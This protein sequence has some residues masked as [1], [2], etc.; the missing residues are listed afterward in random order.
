VWPDERLCEHAVVLG[1]TGSGKT[2][3]LL[4]LALAHMRSGRGLFFLDFH[5][6][7]AVELTAL[8]SLCPDAEGRFILFDPTNVQRSPG[9]N[10]LAVISREPGELFRRTSELAKILRARWGAD[11]LGVR[12]EETLRNSLYVLAEQG[13]TLV[14]LPLLL[15]S[16]AVR[17]RLLSNTGNA[18]V[19]SFWIDR[20]G[21]LSDSMRRAYTEPTIN[22]I[23]EFIGD[24]AIRHILGQTE[25]TV[26][27]ADAMQQGKWV[28]VNLAKGVLGE[29]SYLLGNL[30]MAHLQAEVMAR[31]KIPKAERNV[32]AL[33][34]DEVQN[35]AEND[36]ATFLSETRKFAISVCTASQYLLQIPPYLRGAL[37]IAG[38]QMFFRLSAADAATLAPELS[39]TQRTRY[40][41]E[42]TA[43]SRGEAVVR[44]GAEPPARIRVPPLPKLTEGDRRRARELASLSCDQYTR[45]RTAIE[46]DIR[47][48]QQHL[49][50]A[51][52]PDE[53]PDEQPTNQGQRNW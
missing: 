51:D 25:N 42:L 39:P 46:A 23:T 48:R 17:A 53:Y 40:V 29:R 9:L 18:D 37:L 41:N 38:T 10:P 2:F 22:K 36:V 35:L 7:A 1:K 14:D 33:I 31:A 43:L 27:F 3:A 32:C 4:H 44:I 52:E 34:L 30:L 8:A 5:G 24:P 47:S 13:L 6:D 28:V 20:F 21:Q 19:R 15:S 50:P 11:N 49:A 26:D 16:D 45:A 12:V